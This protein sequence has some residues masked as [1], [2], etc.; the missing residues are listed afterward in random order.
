MRSNSDDA[1]KKNCK[2]GIHVDLNAY[3]IGKL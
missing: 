3:Y 2:L 1:I